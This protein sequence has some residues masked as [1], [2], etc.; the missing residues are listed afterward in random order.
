[1]EEKDK[2]T[3]E[4]RPSDMRFLSPEQLGQ[5]LAEKDWK[6]AL[7]ILPGKDD[8]NRPTPIARFLGG[9]VVLFPYEYHTTIKTGETWECQITEDNPTFMRA[10]P[11]RK[12]SGIKLNGDA[13][14]PMSPMLARTFV[15]ALK[16]KVDAIAPELTVLEKEREKLDS[17]EKDLEEQLHTVKQRLDELED[18]INEKKGELTSYQKA[19]DHYEPQCQSSQ[20]M[21]GHG[22]E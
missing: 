1:M 22:S 16:I 6:E 5:Y 2:T 17:R 10:T 21:N 7:F 11:I 8:D 3:T 9:K 12:I 13:L 18:A 15:D 20:D 14:P 4:R 19:L